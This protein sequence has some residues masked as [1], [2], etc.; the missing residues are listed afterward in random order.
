MM[1]F[2]IGISQLPSND[3]KELLTALIKDIVEK[4]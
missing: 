1:S 3:A 4:V 2:L